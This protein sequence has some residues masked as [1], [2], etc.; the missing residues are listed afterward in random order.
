[1]PERKVAVLGGDYGAQHAYFPIQILQT[2]HYD[3][4][5]VSPDRQKGEMA[6]IVYHWSEGD[7]QSYREAAGRPIPITEDFEN[8]NTDNYSGLIIPGARAPEHLSNN[9]KATSLVRE[10]NDE[11]LPIIGMCHGPLLLAASDVVDGVKCTGIPKTRRFLEMAGAEWIQPTELD[12]EG[13][14]KAAEYWRGI[15]VDGNII[16]AP[17]KVNFPYVLREFLRQ[18]EGSDEMILELDKDNNRLV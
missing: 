18:V 6:K 11:N 2:L 17:L 12:K 16:T 8:V 10:F 3:V 4:D 15:V 5:Y 7:E 1:M 13:R 9:E 14:G